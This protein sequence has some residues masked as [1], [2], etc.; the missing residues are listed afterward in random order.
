MRLMHKRYWNEIETFF[1]KELDRLE[2]P[3]IAERLAYSYACS[4]LYRAKF[5]AARNCPERI[6]S[7]EALADV[8]FTEKSEI[9]AAQ[10]AGGLFGPYQCATFEDIVRI[11]GTGGTSGQPMRIGWTTSDAD[12]HSE[13]GA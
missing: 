8:P 2:G 9:I 12:L 4:P 3:L 7:K 10:R 13:M 5:D 1:A 11:V 6:N